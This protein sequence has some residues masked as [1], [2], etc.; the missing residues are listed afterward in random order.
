MLAN[1]K[2]EMARYNIRSRDIAVVIGKTERAVKNRI[3]GQVEISIEDVRQIRDRFF[4]HCTLDY[5]LAEPPAQP[6]PHDRSA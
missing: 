4:P 6:Q 5:L 3:N 2:A 1:L